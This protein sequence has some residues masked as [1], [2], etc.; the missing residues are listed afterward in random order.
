MNDSKPILALGLTPA[1]Q[2]IHFFDKFVPGEVN[3]SSRIETHAGGKASNVA[4][5][6]AALGDKAYA[7]GFNGGIA[8]RLAAADVAARGAMP[9]FTPIRAETR[10][11]HS[12][13]DLATRSVT[14]LVQEF[15]PVTEDDLA[16]FTRKMLALLGK[17]GGR[18]ISGTLPKTFPATAYV[19][20]GTKATAL[21]IPWLLDSQKAPLLATLPCRPTVA[22]L[23]RFELGQTFGAQ[24]RTNAACVKL[25]RKITEAG[26]EWA[27][28]TDGARPALLVS[29][30]GGLWTLAPERLAKKDLASPIGSGDCTAAGII[31]GLV[32]GWDMPEAVAF[33]LACGTANARSYVPADFVPPGRSPRAD[34]R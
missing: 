17:C 12:L 26:A 22:K 23:N 28:M 9:A 7:G 3:R 34:S 29:S 15:P 16:R 10:T 20:F 5:A 27:L 8:G 21:G 18:T 19:P 32:Q 25:L 13:V 4:M 1:L 33:G 31:H 24:T 30:D 6:L 2:K 14:E 11:C